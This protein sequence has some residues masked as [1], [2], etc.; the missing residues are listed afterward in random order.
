MKIKYINYK[1]YEYELLK[2][3]LDELGKQGYDCNDLSMFSLFRK[4]DHPIH[5]K[6]EFYLSKE[7]EKYKRD[8][9]IAKY[10]E[11]HTEFG[12]FPIYSKNG[13]YVFS[14]DEE[15]TF[16]D[17]EY[18]N[19]IK[20]AEK[21]VP[22]IFL[23]LCLA[24]FITTVLYFLLFASQSVTA[25]L[26][27]GKVIAYVGILLLCLSFVYRLYNDFHFSSSIKHGSL[28]LD[29]IKK[30]HTIAISLLMI[31]IIMIAGG[32]FEDT[33]NVK[34]INYDKHPYIQLSDLGHN[35]QSVINTTS[36]HSFI[37]KNSYSTYESIDNIGLYTK[38]YDFNSVS[39]ATKYVESLIKRPYEVI[40]TK[41]EKKD[42]MYYG[43]YDD[44]LNTIIL[45]KDNK[46]VIVTYSKP[47]T[48]QHIDTIRNF[49]L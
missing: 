1:P 44:T 35:E 4:K 48:K 8:K 36:S 47:L 37:I 5:Y 41:V 23:L 18:S 17:N 43:Y 45:Q 20:L 29:K 32:L 2:K 19:G 24:I 40:S 13:M 12:Y 30:T 15:H 16:K 11:K 7:K 38:E 3:E 14:G 21:R 39:Q 46:V 34:E 9:D 27:Y 25:F 49:Y 42:D 6:V 22:N 26:T 28:S 31:S 10:Y 33:L